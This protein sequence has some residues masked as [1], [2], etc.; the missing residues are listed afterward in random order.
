VKFALS[1]TELQVAGD[2]AF[3]SGAY[4]ITLTPDAEGQA[5]QDVGK[6]ITVYQRLSSGGW[7]VAR[8]IWNSD[9]P[10]PGMQ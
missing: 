5:I 3:E 2:R 10:L 4:T 9:Q 1:V 8:D 7:A 6:Y